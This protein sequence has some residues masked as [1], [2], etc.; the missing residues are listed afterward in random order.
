MSVSS[1]RWIRAA[2]GQAQLQWFD[3]R[4]S[5]YEAAVLEL[6]RLAEASGRPELEL[7]IL[8]CVYMGKEDKGK[9]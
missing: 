5:D 2:A 3:D 4:W 7:G 8:D 6:R 1:V 9:D